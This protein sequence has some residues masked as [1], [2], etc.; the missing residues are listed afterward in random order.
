MMAY[1]VGKLCDVDDDNI[2]KGISNLNLTGNRLEYKKYKDGIMLIDDTYNASLDSIKASLEILRKEKSN[3]KIAVIGDVLELGSFAEE[4]HREIGKELLDSDLDFVIT[5]GE[6]TKYTDLY[7][8]ENGFIDI[9]HFDKE[10][11]CYC[12][13]EELLK[14]GD[15]VLFKGSHGIKLNN[16]VDYLMKNK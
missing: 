6:N 8:R 15:T 16:I 5:I 9:R 12:Y 3:R 2:K 10:N 13:I 11:D 1:V 4:I 14:E 7:L